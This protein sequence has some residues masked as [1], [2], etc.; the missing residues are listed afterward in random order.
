MGSIN[1]KKAALASG[2]TASLLGAFLV[3]GAALGGVGAA[4]PAS[5]GTPV[6]T[7][8]NATPEPAEVADQK[9]APEQDEAPVDPA[10][11]KITEDQA[12][13]AALAKFPGGSVVKAT[14]EDENGTLIWE[15]K[16]T[17]TNKQEHEVKVDATSGQVLGVQAEGNEG[18]GGSEGPETNEGPEGND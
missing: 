2:L 4:P 9:G 11:A 17:D 13:Q 18:P 15:V 10:R 3:G 7:G 1:F 12:R 5:P 16:V 6:I 8:Q 14:L